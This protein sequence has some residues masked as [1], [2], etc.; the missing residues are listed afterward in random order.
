MMTSARIVL[1]ALVLSLLSLRPAPLAAAAPPSLPPEQGATP[2]PPPP[3][4]QPAAAPEET[5]EAGQT[6]A[7]KPGP[8]P[9]K[10]QGDKPGKMSRRQQ[11]E[12]LRKLPAKYQQWLAEVDPLITEEEKSAFLALDKDYQRDAFIKRF[13]EVRNPNK[14]AHNMF[15][16]RW[17][18][19][20]EEAKRRFGNLEDERARV[21]LLNGEP[22]AIMVSSCST[23]LWPLEAWYYHGSDRLREDFLLVFYRHWG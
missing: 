4:A 7:G 11:K 10:G 17:D 1:P 22:A 6:A 8:K 23:L 20:V 14:G 12:A 19:R 18:E 9:A 3:A 16:E 15:Q 2:P 21:L 13:W 5:P